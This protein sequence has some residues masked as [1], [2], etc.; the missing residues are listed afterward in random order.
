MYTTYRQAQTNTYVVVGKKQETPSTTTLF[1]TLQGGTLPPY[2]PG[3]Y[4]TVYFPGS[5][6]LNGKAYSISSTP[7]EKLL[8]I[9]VRAIGEFSHR[10]CAMNCGDTIL[11][12]P[13]EGFFYT[14]GTETDLVMLAGGIGVTPF[15]GIILDAL[16]RAPL[17]ELFLFQSGRTCG[18]IVFERGLR[19]LAHQHKKLRV[20]RF[21][22]RERKVAVPL[23]MTPRRMRTEDILQTIY[24]PTRSTFMICGAVS[25]VREQQRGLRASG[26][27]EEQILTE[28]CF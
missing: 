5:S 1:L 27:L 16:Q 15:R 14:E 21:I 28:V 18:D 7:F 8:T 25:F 19:M 22:T 17:R 10:L 11:G 12:S 26:V 13:P 6:T 3:H 9:T 24:D 2:T 4:L 20:M 23:E